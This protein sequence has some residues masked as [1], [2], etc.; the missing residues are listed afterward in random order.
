MAKKVKS[1]TGVF[2]PFWD[3]D[4]LSMMGGTI[5]NFGVH[6]ECS[7]MAYKNE[8]HL[9]F[10]TLPLGGGQGLLSAMHRRLIGNDGV[11][12]PNYVRNHK[13]RK[14]RTFLTAL[15]EN[16]RKEQF[17]MAIAAEINGTNGVAGAANIIKETWNVSLRQPINANVWMS[18][19]PSVTGALNIMKSMKMG[20]HFGIGNIHSKT[21]KSGPWAHPKY[22]FGRYFLAHL[23][24]LTGMQT[25]NHGGCS[26]EVISAPI[27]LMS[28]MFKA[29]HM[30]LMRAYH[31]NNKEIPAEYL[32]LWVDK[33]LDDLESPDPMRLQ[34]VRNVKKPL[35]VAGVKI[36]VV[37]SLD[38]LMFERMTVPKFKSIKAQTD[39]VRSSVEGMLDNERRENGVVTKVQKGLSDIFDKTV[40]QA[41]VP[42]TLRAEFMDVAF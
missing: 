33:S 22:L 11:A 6:G 21:V 7:V 3:K 2:N 36:V 30:S 41:P 31:M 20:T 1:V 10:Y 9:P 23:A 8:T 42:N 27:P 13:D 38:D 4:A 19:Y 28:L 25:F 32:E 18:D 17:M 37:D 40:P 15:W 24:D 34:Y 5:R 12:V 39:W 26:T 35:E 14:W 16:G 29:E